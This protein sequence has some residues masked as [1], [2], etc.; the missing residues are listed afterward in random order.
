MIR[1]SVK[2]ICICIFLFQSILLSQSFVSSVSSNTVSPDEQFEATFSFS[3]RDVNRIKNFYPPD[4]N[5][6]L[7][8]S[9]PNQSTSMQI[10]NGAVSSK[11]SYS[12]YLQPK[13]IGKY[14]IGSASIVYDDRT[15]KTNPLTIEVKAGTSKPDKKGNNQE[16]NADMEIKDNLFILAAV[17]KNKA[18]VGEQVT[19][20]YKLYTRLNIASQMSV[21][22][23][24][25][26]QGFWAEELETSSN[27]LFTTEVYNGKQYR[28]GVLKKAAL[29]PSQTGELTISPFELKVPVQIEKKRKTGNNFFDD[30]FNDPFFNR[31]MVDYAVKSNSVKI[32]ALPLPEDKPES[33]NGMVGSFSLNSDLNKKNVKTNEPISLKINV[34]G[35]GNIQLLNIPEVKLPQGFEKY[36]PK[37]TNLIN[38]K[39]RISGSKTFEYL[40]IPRTSGRKEIPPA[41]FTYFD[42]DKKSFVTLSTSRYTINVEKG[43]GG[44][45]DLAGYSKEDIKLLGEDIR[46]IKTSVD[47]INKKS[48]ILLNQFGFWTAAAV[49]LFALI[50]LVLFKKRNEKLSANLQLL[51]YQRAQKI[52][53]SKLKKAKICMDANDQNGFYSE[54]SQ[55]LYGYLEDKFHIPKSELSLDRAVT[56]L[57]KK[58]LEKDLIMNF[59]RCSEKCEYIRF[60]PESNGIAEMEDMYSR[61]A[62]IIIEIEK[63]LGSKKNA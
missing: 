8:I 40:I 25:S 33:F 22:K 28:V 48:G 11:V 63:S 7:V 26:Y 52:V 51:R 13:N 36:E 62:D 54:I 43:S 32:N 6:F 23:L 44:E 17:D 31:E 15:Y 29:F 16:V 27:I 10:I 47:D 61:S 55:A 37:V 58:K 56:E 60:A 30:F 9:G 5:N 20:T 34:S 49:P 19:V 4:F 18:Y 2:N 35:T 12:Y 24:P 42:P 57:G 53:K 50:G 1:N 46:Y 14:T 3:G 39:S 59:K 38:R 21:S 41:E 45:S